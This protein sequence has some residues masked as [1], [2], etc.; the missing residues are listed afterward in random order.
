MDL[1]TVTT[2]SPGHDGGFDG[3]PRWMVVVL[4]RGTYLGRELSMV[5]L[6]SA[7]D[8]ANLRVCVAVIF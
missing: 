2:E 5:S 3:K 8:F 6:L 4:G 7:E 1:R